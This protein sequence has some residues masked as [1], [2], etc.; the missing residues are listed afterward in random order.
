MGTPDVTISIIDDDW[1][2][3]NSLSCMLERDGLSVRTFSRASAFLDEYDPDQPGCLILDVDLP[4]MNGFELQHRL[5]E[6]G[7][8]IPIIFISS[9]GETCMAV[10]A[11]KDGAWDFLEKPYIHQELLNSVHKAVTYE[12]NQ[13]THRVEIDR[14]QD[15]LKQLTLRQSEILQLLLTGLSSSQIGFRLSISRKTVDFHRARIQAVL[16][17]DSLLQILGQYHRCSL[18]V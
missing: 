12:R 7:L 5:N 2:V 1:E 13:H 15:R 10:H 9:R 8:P 11:M 17:C 14:F 16:K 4:G 6:K 18:A 3:L